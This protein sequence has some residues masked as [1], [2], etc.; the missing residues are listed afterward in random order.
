MNRS[1]ESPPVAF[2]AHELRRYV[3][4]MSD[5]SLASGEGSHAAPRV[6][7]GLRADLAEA[8]RAELPPEATGHDGYAIRVADEG[9]DPRIVVGGDTP[10][11]VVYAVYDI[12]ER[13]GCRWFHPPL[14]ARDPELVPRSPDLTLP[15]GAWAVA[16]PMR[17]RTLHWF[18][19]RTGGRGAWRIDATPAEL[20]VEIDWAMKSRYDTFESSAAELSPDHPLYRALVTEA[21]RRGM[22]IRAPGHNFDLFF[23]DDDAAFAAHPEWFGMRDGRRV[24]HA[25][26]G[27]QFCWTN[28]AARALFV[29]N[30]ERFVRE[31]PEIDVLMLSG[32]DGGLF[33]QPCGCPECARRSPSDNVLVL[34][35]QVATRLRTTA[36]KVVVETLGGYQYSDALPAEVRPE[37]DVRIVWAHWGRQTTG[38]YSS[39]RYPHSAD[40]AAWSNIFGGRATAFQYYSDLF[41]TPWIGIPVPAQIAGDRSFLIGIHADGFLNL[42]YPDGYWWRAS[43][44]A[45]LAGR[46]YYDASLDPAELLRDYARRYHGAAAGPEM[47]AYY[48]EWA[49]TPGLGYRTQTGMTSRERHL[50]AKQQG[51]IDRA[52]KAAGHDAVVL[53]RLD[54]SASLQGLAEL[55]VDTGIALNEAV[56]ARAVGDV[57][58][59]Q[60]RLARAR[61][62]LEETER[63][64]SALVTGGGGVLDPSFADQAIRLKKAELARA[65]RMVEP[66][67]SR[68]VPARAPAADPPAAGPRAAR[69]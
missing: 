8:E 61:G 49:R 60:K 29:D 3:E 53:Y 64:A 12:L 30:V 62:R 43:L 9:G 24:R 56:A 11:A 21:R 69:H 15:A 1:P 18:E 5:A 37:P 6:V 26:H 63:R 39:P 46:S 10:R 66:A 13:L 47:V 55:L 44:N 41:A 22:R 16:S 17:F 68:P 52:R 28:A 65:A 40:L 67:A 42:L 20:G 54:K 34:I 14:D 38:S 36:P 57:R 31:R 45:H 2:A 23:P 33:A 48:D 50:L 51:R 27:A 58:E 7:L 35:N 59:T 25:A 19:W 4:R 32:L